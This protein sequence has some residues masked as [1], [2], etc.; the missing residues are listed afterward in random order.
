MMSVSRRSF[1]KFT[2]GAAAAA[3]S[4]IAGA[5]TL[6]ATGHQEV[7]GHERGDAIKLIT[8]VSKLRPNEPFEFSYPDASSPCVMIK[9]GYP[10]SGG[11]GPGGDVVAFSRLCSHMGCPVSYETETKVFQ[12]PCHFSIFDAEKRGQ[13]VCGQATASLPSITLRYA[14]SDGSISAVGVDGLIYGR[15]ENTLRG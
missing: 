13:M 7:V 14:E 4:T 15:T 3:S 10:V 12:C 6:Q 5:S 8:H 1:L 9:L 2:G 11:I